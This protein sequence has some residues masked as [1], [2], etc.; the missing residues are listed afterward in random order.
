MGAGHSLGPN[1]LVVGTGGAEIW[2]DSSHSP[3][4][5]VKAA[6][7]P[8]TA[9]IVVEVRCCVVI[10]EHVL[11]D[12]CCALHVF[13]TSGIAVCTRLADFDTAVAQRYGRGRSVGAA[14]ACQAAAAHG[15]CRRNHHHKRRTSCRYVNHHGV[16]WCMMK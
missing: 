3:A 8:P 15:G 12:L 4:L 14:D 2:G 6:F 5:H 16:A 11:V 9:V 13:L 10:Q 7:V 1:G